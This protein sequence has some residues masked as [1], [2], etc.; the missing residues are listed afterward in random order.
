M[1]RGPQHL[2]Q[3]LRLVDAAAVTDENPGRPEM[4]ALRPPAMMCQCSA[5]S[6]PLARAP[7]G[8]LRARYLDTPCAPALL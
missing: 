5:Q 8:P 2:L 1:D 7:D 6:S 3:A 4:P